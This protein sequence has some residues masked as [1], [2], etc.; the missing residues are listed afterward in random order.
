MEQRETNE[1]DKCT[2]KRSMRQ[3]E[4]KSQIERIAKEA[5]IGAADQ[6]DNAILKQAVWRMARQAFRRWHRTAF[7]RISLFSLSSS[8]QFNF[9]F[10]VIKMYGCN[11]NYDICM[12]LASCSFAFRLPYRRR[13]FCFEC[14]RTLILIYHLL[15]LRT[16]N[17]RYLFTCFPS[18]WSTKIRAE[19]DSGS[20]YRRLFVMQCLLLYYVYT[21]PLSISEKLA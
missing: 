13:F 18:S 2:R 17:E 16:N 15:K 9:I 6:P 20:R 4:R 3:S 21:Y 19:N 14:K 10:N 11:R 12:P 8:L 1:R 7:N 5:M